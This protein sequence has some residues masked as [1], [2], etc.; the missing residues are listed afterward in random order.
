MRTSDTAFKTLFIGFVPLLIGCVVALAQD[1]SRLDSAK[2]PHDS[3]AGRS[4]FAANCAGCHGLDGKGGDKAP[5]I[6]TR[7]EIRQQSDVALLEVLQQGVPR[8]SMPAFGFLGDA[9]LRSLVGYLR[10]LQGNPDAVVLSGDSRHGKI[11]FFGKGRC[12]ECHIVHGE[13]GFL[14]SDLSEYARSRS[15]EAVRDA[16]LFPNRNLDPRNRAVLAILR[17]GKSVEG[18]IRNEDNFSIQIAT[19]DGTTYLLTKSQ[20]QSLTYREESAMPADYGARLSAS[21]LDDLVNYLHV[22]SAKKAQGKTNDEDEFANE[23]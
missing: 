7:P 13:G 23:E 15:P 8:K 3:A 22:I 2:T 5:D 20:L 17:G 11:L 21:E 10:T 16:I 4:I 14:A 9:A 1:A 6:A 12:S 19:L 18:V